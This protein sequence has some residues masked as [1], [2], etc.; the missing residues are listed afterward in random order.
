MA[1]ILPVFTKDFRLAVGKTAVHSLSFLLKAGN[2]EAYWTCRE[3]P[4]FKHSFHNSG[5]HRFAV[6]QKEPR[7]P[8]E[9]ASLV[10]YPPGQFCTVGRIILSTAGPWEQSERPNKLQRGIRLPLDMFQ[11]ISIGIS[12]HHPSQHFNTHSD[13]HLATLKIS[14]SKFLTATLFETDLGAFVNHQALELFAPHRGTKFIQR[15]I[16]QPRGNG[17]ND[18]LINYRTKLNTFVYWAHHNV[19]EENLD[20]FVERH[21]IGQALLQAHQASLMGVNVGPSLRE[22]LK[23][24][25]PDWRAPID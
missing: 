14:D 16:P 25:A 8:L 6:H 15:A 11:I 9:S 13:R 2:G 18:V 4:K 5:R 3:D 7:T 22:G 1:Q 19:H 23:V 17:W 12:P 10:G 24:L 20:V 21:P